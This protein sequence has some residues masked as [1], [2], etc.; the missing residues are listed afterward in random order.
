MLTDTIGALSAGVLSTEMVSV[1]IVRLKVNRWL[2]AWELAFSC[3]RVSWIA[4][5]LV[6]N[7]L[8]PCDGLVGNL[9]KRMVC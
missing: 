1:A 8:L 7:R 6:G 4:S 9:K 3:L 2:H 5:N